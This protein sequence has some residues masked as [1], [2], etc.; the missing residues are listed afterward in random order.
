MINFTYDVLP[1]RAIFGNG[2]RERLSSE[3]ERLGCGRAIILSTSGQEKQARELAQK[4]G[5][6]AAG[7]F[8][9]AIIHTP[10]PISEHAVALARSINADCIIAL[11]GGSAIGLGKAIALRTDLPQIAL[12]TTYAG[13]EMTPII[14][15]TTE[16]QKTTKRTLKVLPEVVMYDPEL[17]LGLPVSVSITSGINA[18][19]HAVEALYAQD[20]NPIVSLLAEE[21]IRAFVSSL[22]TIAAS[23]KEGS[24]RSD[25]MYGAWL[26]GTCLGAVGMSLHHK[27]C[28]VLGGT[29]DLPHAET[30]TVVLMHAIAYNAPVEPAVISAVAKAMGSNEAAAGLYDFIARLGAKQSLRELGMPEAGIEQAALLAIRNPYWNPRKLEYQLVYELIRR[31][32]AGEAPDT[33]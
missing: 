14:G 31:A 7:I 32:W 29:F 6:L 24:A 17:T 16:G 8:P 10:V 19:A 5:K 21:S 3:I 30:H 25:A 33:T 15:E 27:L 1:G 13:C 11:G 2:V 26:A 20:R 28:H 12:P 22:P 18:I 4:I 23:P 9:G